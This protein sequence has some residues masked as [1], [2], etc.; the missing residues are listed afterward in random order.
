MKTTE[1]IAESAYESWRNAQPFNDKIPAFQEQTP[2]AR[3]TWT[4]FAKYIAE[5]VVSEYRNYEAF[6]FFRDQQDLGRMACEAHH[7]I[8]LAAGNVDWNSFSP[9]Y[10]EAWVEQMRKA[11]L[12][13][14]IRH[15]AELDLGG[16]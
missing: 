2:E 4:S 14:E 1:Q 6:T 13:S 15:R 16:V 9:E 12:R 11:K 8:Y 3:S 7:I 5:E 10:Q